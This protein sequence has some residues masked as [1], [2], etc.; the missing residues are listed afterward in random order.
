MSLSASLRDFAQQS[1]FDCV[2]FRSS[3]SKFRK[4]GGE[5]SGA[6]IVLILM[7]LLR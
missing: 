7:T 1:P 4:M 5:M 3:P 6:E 2:T